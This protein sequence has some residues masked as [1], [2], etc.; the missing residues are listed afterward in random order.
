MREQR[1][2][3]REE[4]E[5]GSGGKSQ[6]KQSLSPDGDKE[7]FMSSYPVLFFLPTG[8][9]VEGPW[10]QRANSIYQLGPVSLV[11]SDMTI[12]LWAKKGTDRWDWE[13][14]RISQLDNMREQVWER[15]QIHQG[16]NF[17]LALLDGTGSVLITLEWTIDRRTISASSWVLAIGVSGNKRLDCFIVNW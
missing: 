11:C 14:Q 9:T 12:Y 7:R 2:I 16:L 17:L 13:V 8:S 5:G 10:K 4:G 15:P 1:E 3:N 6:R